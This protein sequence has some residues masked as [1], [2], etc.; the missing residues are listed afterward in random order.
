MKI[1]QLF[2]LMLMMS[3]AFSLSAQ[4]ASFY[5]KYAEKGDK[6]AMYNL[7]DCYINGTG[8]V[9]QDMN[10]ATYWLTKAAK[11]KYAPAQVK[12]AYCYIY[13]AGV[14][15][16]YKQ[17]WELAQKAVKKSDPEAH[18]LTA[19]MYKD[20]VYVP[21][22]ATKWMSWLRSAADLG[23]ATAQKDLG[24]LY[25]YGDENLKIEQDFPTAVRW[26][27]L[28]DN[29]NEA[30]AAYYLGLCN[31]NGIEM[32]EDK[33]KALEYYYKAA[34]GGNAE[35][36]LSYGLAYLFGNGVERDFSTAYTYI[37]AAAEQGN[38]YACSQMGDFYNFGWGRD[39]DYEK[40]IEWYNKA[41]ELGD[42]YSLS[43]LGTLYRFGRGVAQ[44]D[45]KA[46]EWYKKSA[47]EGMKDGQ[48]NVGES[49]FYGLGV[50]KNPTQALKYY[51]LAADEND[52]NRARHTLYHIYKDGVGT[53]KDNQLALQYLREAADEDYLPAVYSLGLEYYFGE[54]LHQEKSKAIELITKSA[55]N[56]YTFGSGVLGTMYYS[57]NDLVDK[58]YDKAFKYLYEAAQ[59]PSDF[60]KEL[61]GEIYRDLGACYRFGRGTEVNHSLA[62]YY[63]EQ[64]AQY[65]DASAFDAVKAL[66]NN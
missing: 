57:G 26:L 11:K 10:Q 2:M 23:S 39:I 29:Q 27:K 46:F 36:Q 47:D 53:N 50:D 63:T 22:S 15:K 51:K 7:A 21:K 43:R 25:L 35:G 66:R 48:Y 3:I 64:A 30:A 32:P 17:A 13:G 41:I 5:K 55:E 56:G 49:Y 19:Q 28:A 54:I 52:D 18:Y 4:D 61:L 34:V 33:Q 16:D 37:N 44:N 60:E 9:S 38:S 24:I 1:K 62:S 8:G 20:G 14:L 42:K 59:N 45:K 65:G 31:E 12:L 40:A 58:D 6:E